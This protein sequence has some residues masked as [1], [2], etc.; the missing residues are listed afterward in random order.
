MVGS[1]SGTR[2]SSWRELMPS[3]VDNHDVDRFLTEVLPSL[4]EKSPARREIK[5]K[6][7]ESYRNGLFAAFDQPTL[8]AHD[9]A[10]GLALAS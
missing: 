8:A 3:F 10:P 7:L 9:R 1:G 2:S 4:D 5:E 6:I